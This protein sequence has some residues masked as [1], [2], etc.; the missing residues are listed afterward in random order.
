MKSEWKKKKSNFSK[1]SSAVTWGK[2]TKPSI[3]SEINSE[4][5]PLQHSSN[6]LPPEAQLSAAGMRPSAVS[7]GPL[8]QQAKNSKLQL[9]RGTGS[10]TPYEPRARLQ[11]GLSAAPEA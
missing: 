2:H 9:G 5:E 11:E 10:H 1:L 3:K 4:E 6:P 7:L 8:Q